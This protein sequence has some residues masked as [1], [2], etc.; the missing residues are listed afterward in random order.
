MN[1]PFLKEAHVR[2][3]AVAPVRKLIVEAADSGLAGVCGSEA[4]SGCRVF[5]SRGEEG[6]LGACPYMDEQLVQ[7]C[8]VAP[9]KK[10][11]PYS[12]SII[13]RCGGN[14]YQYC[15]LYLTLSQPGYSHQTA[16]DG[17]DPVVDGVRV[18]GK[19][20]YAPNHMWLNA[21]E[22]GSCHVG[23]DGFLARLLG[24]LERISFVATRGVKRPSVTLTVEG[25]TWP[26]MFPNEILISGANLY[27]R[28][29]PSRLAGDP[30]G[31]GWLFEGWEAPGK[32]SRGGLMTG[33]QAAEWMAQEMDRLNEYVRTCAA[34]A[35]GELGVVLNDGGMPDA[36]L[37]KQLP[38]D[39]V[40]RLFNE[41]FSPQASWKSA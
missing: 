19:L 35:A 3:C 10:Y 8:S 25:M 21:G 16:G 29:D 6:G 2:G 5:Q 37:L 38:P 36:G 23:V 39:E 11:I 22:N 12:E 17:R 14:N 7:Y 27:L 15:S 4:H 32:P 18:P 9:V 41:F 20:Y 24:S 40:A 26:L 13:S 31:S 30:Y 28:S 34:S 1:C 33:D